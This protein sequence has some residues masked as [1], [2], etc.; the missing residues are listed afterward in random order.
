[1]DENIAMILEGLQTGQITPDQVPPEIL[2][3][4]QGQ[5]GEQ[6]PPE[7]PMTYEEMPMEGDIPPEIMAILQALQTGEITPEQIPPEIMQQ[8][9]PFIQ[10]GM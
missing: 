6:M 3:M 2:A 7:E 8:L 5:G 4:L 1:M 10:G 9:L